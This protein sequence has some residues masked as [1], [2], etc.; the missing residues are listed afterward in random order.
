MKSSPDPHLWGVILAGG[1][2]SRFW[3]A[4]TPSR[5]KQ[6]LAL[7]SEQPLVR[8]TV[9][10]ITPL[11]PLDRLRILAGEH[12]AA[13]M[14]AAVPELTAEHFYLEPR[15]AGTA[16][17]LAW[18]AA[19]IARV[20]PQAVM[21]SLHSDHVIEPAEL[22]REQ[23]AMAA[24]LARQTGRLFTLGAI[25]D[26]PE[27]G[28]GYIRLGP[29]LTESSAA[30]EVAEFV[31]KPDAATAATYLASGKY[32]WNTGIFIWRVRDL[33]DQLQ[34][35]TPE[36]S[37]LIP[38]LNAGDT[39]AFFDRVP[40]LTIDT[41]L[42]E[43]SD[44]VGV[45]PARFG[46][47]DVGAWDALF[48]TRAL[49]DHGNV[50]VGDSFAVDSSGSALVADDGPVVAFGVHDLVIVRTS[51]ITLVTHRDRAAELKHLLD[52]LPERLRRLE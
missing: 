40:T 18:A 35:H 14:R 50:L 31:E 28:Y 3:P 25:P 12:L 45:V 9:D 37:P 2:G 19:Q 1:I 26:R 8:D 30:F 24:E 49:D 33:L 11:I 48:R 27:T 38:L 10:R 39:S 46:W 41:G 7:A 34:R 22:F 43:R 4:S 20:D 32:L 15:A 6:L 29:P 17:V 44:R 5:P 36:I 52:R 23:V 42:L 21:V 51:G 47:D 16:P 13:P